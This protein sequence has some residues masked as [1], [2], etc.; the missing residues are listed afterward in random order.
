MSENPSGKSND[1]SIRNFAIKT[2][3]VACAFVASTWILFDRL[4]SI[5]DA[6]ITQIS[7][8]VKF[9]PRVFWPRLET[10]IEKAADPSQDLSPERKA[11]LMGAIR[12]LVE[13]WKPF[14]TELSVDVSR[15]P[16]AEQK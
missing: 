2:I 5:V 11:K 9:Q 13:R 10:Q 15:P 14:L 1:N 16:A 4:D 6:H 12:I 7:D 8:M 3:I